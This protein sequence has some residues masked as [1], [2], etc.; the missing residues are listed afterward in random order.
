M[1]AAFF[2]NQVGPEARWQ[3]VLEQIRF[4]DFIPDTR[5]NRNTLLFVEV[6]ITMKVG[7]RVLKSC[8]S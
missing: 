6:G 3:D 7:S 4:V 5:R 1:V 2:K 8:F